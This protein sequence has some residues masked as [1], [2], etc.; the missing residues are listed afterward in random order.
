M[1]QQAV[2]QVLERALSDDAFRAQLKANFDAAIKGYDLTADEIGALKKGDEGTLRAMGVDE[3]L[4][5]GF[6]FYR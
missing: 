3:R 2:I 6:T 5:K 1:S 4:S